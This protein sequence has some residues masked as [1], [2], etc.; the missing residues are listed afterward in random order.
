MVSNLKLNKIQTLIRVNPC[1]T[2]IPNLKNSDEIETQFENIEMNPK[3]RHKNVDKI[4]SLS[5]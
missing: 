5:N 4:N 1:I 3:S 2:I